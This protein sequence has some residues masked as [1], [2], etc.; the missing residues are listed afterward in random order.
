MKTRIGRKM[1][2]GRLS[3]AVKRPGI[4]TRCWVSLA[5]ALEDSFVDKDHGV[6]VKEEFYCIPIYQT[7]LG[8]IRT[9]NE[10]LQCP[11]CNTTG[12]N[13]QQE[14]GKPSGKWNKA[15]EQGLVLD[16]D[17]RIE[18]QRSNRKVHDHAGKQPHRL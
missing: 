17:S 6:F 10:N 9:S 15:E 4:D 7:D 5:V 3:S 8:A 11:F 1:D 2:I 13:Q 18:G 16:S 14:R 12:R